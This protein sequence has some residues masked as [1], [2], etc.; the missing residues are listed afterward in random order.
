MT[1]RA[2]CRLLHLARFMAMYYASKAFVY[3]FS[4]ALAEELKESG[5]SVTTLCPGMTHSEFHARANLKRSAALPMMSA[6]VMPK[7][8]LSHHDERQA[9][10][11]RKHRENDADTPGHSDRGKNKSVRGN[12]EEAFRTFKLDGCMAHAEHFRA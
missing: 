3:S 12:N 2:G 10:R 8:R 7:N 9:N 1:S 6:E 4:C 11:R 5:G